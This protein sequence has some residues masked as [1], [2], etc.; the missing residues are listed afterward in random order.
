MIEECGNKHYDVRH[1]IC[2]RCGSVH[3][4][5]PR[6][7][8]WECCAGKKPYNVETSLCCEGSVSDLNNTR[9]SAKDARCCS[10]VAFFPDRQICCKGTFIFCFGFL[11]KN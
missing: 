1:K 8:K 2:D 7:E 3:F 5:R 11:L 4:V 9:R 6:Y 10:K